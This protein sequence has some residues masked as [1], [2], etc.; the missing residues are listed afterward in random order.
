MGQPPLTMVILPSNNVDNVFFA[1]Y[2]LYNVTQQWQ[3]KLVVSGLSNA[4]H[5]IRIQVKGARNLASTANTVVFDA[6]IDL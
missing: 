2:D 5:T 6:L 3:Y 1:T 4:A